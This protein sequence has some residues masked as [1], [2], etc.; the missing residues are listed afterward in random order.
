MIISLDKELKKQY[1]KEIK[2]YKRRDYF[3][4]YFF[5]I[6]SYTINLINELKEL[7]GDDI[8]EDLFLSYVDDIKYLLDNIDNKRLD[9]NND[10]YKYMI[11]YYGEYIAPDKIHKV[12]K[13]VVK[14][15]INNECYKSVDIYD[16]LCFHYEL[17]KENQKK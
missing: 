5:I 11:N 14:N 2:S 3:K 6:T 17:Y 12:I 1:L 13:D 15:I 10:F 9:K 4:R 8:T 16:C 7:T